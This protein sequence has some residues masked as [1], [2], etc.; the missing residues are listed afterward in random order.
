MTLERNPLIESTVVPI[1]PR[2]VTLLT[3]TY[4]RRESY[5]AQLLG[6]AFAEGVGN[7]VLVSNGPNPALANVAAKYPDRVKLVSLPRNLGSAPGYRHAI[8]AALE[9]P[10]QIFW[11]MDDDN[12][13]TPGALG[14]LLD[15]LARTIAVHGT[16]GSSVL[17]YRDDH[18]SDIGAGIPI[19]IVFPP[20]GSFI[21]FD[22]RILG[23][24]LK[25]R[26]LKARVAPL[27]RSSVVS[28]PYA[29]YGGFVAHRD[30]YQAIGMPEEQ[31]ALY[32]DDHEYTVRVTEQGGVIRLVRNAELVDQEGSWFVDDKQGK[33]A[34]GQPA[35]RRN[36]FVKYLQDGSD[37]RVYYTVRNRAWFDRH[38]Y[39]GPSLLY[40]A[41]KAA[42]LAILRR[43]A[44]KLD[45]G[46]RLA[47]IERAIRDGEGVRLGEQP[48]F[49]LP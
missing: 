6:T 15:E 49:P 14:K 38:R 28:V 3:L 12:A 37:F 18:L 41:N 2:S 44:R 48:D 36:S 25:R 30:C 19:D 45:A 20:R 1:D 11:L 47:L 40:R 8:E 34:D 46:K 21:G 23:F 35:V 39:S 43:Y 27:D 17:G 32:G 29:P 24:K 13:P 22:L 4:G 5:V 7:V 42:F 9:T 10:G 33:N 31:L 16:K 26:A